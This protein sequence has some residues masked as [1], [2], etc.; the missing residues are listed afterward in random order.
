[1][2]GLIVPETLGPLL[3]S[4]MFG[5]LNFWSVLISSIFGVNSIRSDFTQ[6]IIYQYLAMPIKRS[7]YYFSRLIGTWIIV[8][9]FYL[10][11]YFAS[12]ILFSIATNSWVAHSG[13]LLSAIMMG[14]F[15]F[16]CI[17]FSTLYSFFGNRMG[18][19]LLVGTSWLLITLSNSTFRDLPIKEYF[20]NFSLPR[21]LGMIIYTILPRLGNI[22]ELANSFLFQKEITMNLWI[23]FSHLIITTSILLWAGSYFIKKKDF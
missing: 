3:L 22:S 14:V 6:N 17:L 5:F 9:T 13:H 4:M 15:I 11:A 7:D 8:Y 12:L 16:L 2:L 19:L 1:M 10:Y 20:V 21:F 23:E 18:A